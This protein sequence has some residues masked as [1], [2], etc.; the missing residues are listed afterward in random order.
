LPASRRRSLRRPRSRSRRKY[1]TEEDFDFWFVEA[2]SDGT[3]FTPVLTDHSSPASQDQSGINSSGKGID[4]SSGGNYVTVAATLPAGTTHVR[5]GYTTDPGL[6]RPGLLADDI[7]VDGT[8]IGGAEDGEAPWTLAGFSVTTGVVTT[9]HFIAYVA[10]NRQYVGYDSSLA[11][12]YNFGFLNTKPDWVE[13]HPYE[14]G[15]LISYWD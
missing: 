10:E 4:G 14:N 13:Y 5:L 12:V 7:T 3:N 1:D 15:L 6:V 9:F 11:T 8:L 2:S